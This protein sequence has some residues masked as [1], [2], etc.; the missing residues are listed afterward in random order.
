MPGTRHAPRSRTPVS[1]ALALSLSAFIAATGLLLVAATPAGA[2]SAEVTEVP[3]LS[4]RPAGQAEATYL[5]LQLMPG[6]QRRVDIELVNTGSLPISARTYSA[7]A[8]TIINGGFGIG[9]AGEAT[10]P[11]TGWLDYPTE[12]LELAAGEVVTRSLTITVPVDAAPGEHLA[13]LA[14]ENAEPAKGSGGVALDQVVR[15]AIAILVTLPGATEAALEIDGGEHLSIAGRSVVAVSLRN[16]GNVRV[17][18]TGS[19]AVF[20]ASGTEVARVRTTMDSFY[21]RTSTRIEIPLT[22]PLEPGDYT[23]SVALSDPQRGIDVAAPDLTMEVVPAAEPAV[24]ADAGR[25]VAGVP[26]PV[27][28]AVTDLLEDE[29]RRVPVL[30]GLGVLLALGTLGV[31]CRRN[32]RRATIAS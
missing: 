11:T 10:S 30:A 12:V 18:P 19:V 22:T 27:A 2:Q 14:I 21:A 26:L 3:Q 25:S 15:K 6:E 23:F 9:F 31:A 29:E 32:R 28:G 1:I 4:I 8:Y 16:P 20:D 24:A 7:D 13:G 5:D 17:R